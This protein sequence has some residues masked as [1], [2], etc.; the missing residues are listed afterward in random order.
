MFRCFILVCV[1][2]VC[3]KS[4]AQY[5]VLQFLPGTWENV[6]SASR[7]EIWE[8]DGSGFTGRSVSMADDGEENVWE[9]LKIYNKN[10]VLTYEADVVGNE[11]PVSF[12]MTFIAENEVIF[13]NEEHDFPKHIHYRFIDGNHLKVEV[14]AVKGGKTL[15]FEFVRKKS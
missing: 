5:D 4:Y 8:K 7:M 11:A 2:F 3:N 1:L 15:L 14:Y 10:G 9:V 13:S 12:G 6:K